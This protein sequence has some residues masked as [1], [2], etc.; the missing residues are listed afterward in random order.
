VTNLDDTS[1]CE[2]AETCASCGVAAD[3]AVATARVPVGVICLTLC[4]DCHD[5]ERLPRIGSWAQTFDLVFA[6]TVHLGITFDEAA[7]I[8]EA[9][10]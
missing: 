7:A 8:L 4:G 2:L 6:H 10:G 5:D 9:E 1:G 3:L